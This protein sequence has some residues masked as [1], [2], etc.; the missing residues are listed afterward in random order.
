MVFAIIFSARV[1]AHAKGWY[2]AQPPKSGSIFRRDH[3]QLQ[4]FK[5]TCAHPADAR[6]SRN[7]W[8]R[9]KRRNPGPSGG[10][11]R[12]ESRADNSLID[13]QSTVPGH[14]GRLFKAFSAF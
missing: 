14:G 5:A 10:L 13:G 4:S 11:V 9:W 2:L 12:A 6:R 7:D 3:A 1:I 8:G